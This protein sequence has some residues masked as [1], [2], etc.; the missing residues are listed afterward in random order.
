LEFFENNLTVMDLLQG[1]H[2]EIFAR[3]GVWYG[4]FSYQHT[5]AVIFLKHGK[6][7]PSLLSL[8]L[9]TN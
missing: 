5:N 7:G 9:R 4:K 2:P 3:L 8:L 6:I 1:E